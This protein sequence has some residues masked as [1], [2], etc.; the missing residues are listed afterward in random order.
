MTQIQQVPLSQG[1]AARAGTA[2]GVDSA[3]RTPQAASPTYDPRNAQIGHYVAAFVISFSLLFFQV[4]VSR[5]LSVITWYHFS[6]LPIT[7]AMLGLGVA[8]VLAHLV[9]DSLRGRAGEFLCA[10]LSLLYAVS[11]PVSMLI[12]FAR[13]ISLNDVPFSA[14]IGQALLIFGAILLP[15]TLGGLALTIVFHLNA[16]QFARIYG[17]DFLGAAIG[18]MVVFTLLL[19]ISTPGALVATAALAAVVP[20]VYAICLRLGMFGFLSTGT[21]VVLLLA[22]RLSETAHVF[23]PG[24]SKETRIT[25]EQWQRWSAIS[26]VRATVH[27]GYG[28]EHGLH[29]L[30]PREQT[31]YLDVVIDGSAGTTNNIWHERAAFE[32]FSRQFAADSFYLAHQLAPRRERAVVIGSGAGMDVMAAKHFGFAKVDAVDI[33]PDVIQ[34]LRENALLTYELSY[35]APGVTLH[36]DEGRDFIA[37]SSEAYDLVQLVLVDT[38]AASASGALALAENHLYTA[39]AFEAFCGKLSDQGV[40]TVVRWSHEAPRLLNLAIE[41]LSRIGVRNPREH[42]AMI[43]N[44]RN[45]SRTVNLIVSRAPFSAEQR[46]RLQLAGA[47]FEVFH[48]FTPDASSGSAGGV[49]SAQPLTV[50]SRGG[51]GTAGQ[52]RLGAQTLELKERG[53]HL[54]VVNAEGTEFSAVRS[55]DTC[56]DRTA[57]DRLVEFIDSIPAGAVVAV[58]VVDDASSSL[59]EAAAEALGRLGILAP[60]RGRF[61]AAHAALG[62]K[63][64]FPGFALEARPQ[65]GEASVHVPQ[66]NRVHA[67]TALL[68]TVLLRALLNPAE[69][70]STIARSPVD[71]SPVFDDRPFF[72]LNTRGVSFAPP[73]SEARGNFSFTN[74]NALLTWMNVI[75]AVAVLLV[76]LAPLMAPGSP[77]GDDRPGGLRLGAG[78][79]Y[80]AAIG[81]GFMW[82]EI[83]LLQKFIL[84]L[85]HPVYSMTTILFS[86]LLGSGVG[87]LLGASM[88]RRAGGARWILWVIAAYALF[89]CYGVT[90]L[91]YAFIAATP[92]L[93]VILTVACVASGGLALGMALP[94]GRHVFESGGFQN[95]CWFW[96]VNGAASVLGASTGLLIAT[97][98]GYL[99]VGWFAIVA[100][101]IAALALHLH[102][103][104]A[105]RRPLRMQNASLS[106]VLSG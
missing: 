98:S 94:L 41:G 104:D 10:L 102:D 100:Y 92:A 86:L 29:P 5:L 56:E 20:I 17:V 62:L 16:A 64:A 82:L 40:L 7:C 32:R 45:A 69:R 33:N 19:W 71:I 93:K 96:G 78:L 80:F 36:I 77:R 85:G 12:L 51:H 54:A 15:L 23:A 74:S 46:R 48:A 63:G 97:Q 53:Y 14:A 28:N 81:V 18:S 30:Y 49:S 4:G 21:L 61:N 43:A 50:L 31:E 106:A 76:V 3:M 39:E 60:V 9:R 58:A 87:S 103:L 8:G 38:W 91:I 101:V 2:G 68:D 25:P 6:V 57:S 24:Y 1:T 72:F 83:V 27:Y 84:L 47:I 37:R 75:V 55:F 89:V 52:L 22:V 88:I 79:V 34:A 95:F 99:A 67:Q 26:H 105:V 59:S 11:I 42:V 73:L 13:P 65:P 70:A 35:G 90:P 66:A 44:Q